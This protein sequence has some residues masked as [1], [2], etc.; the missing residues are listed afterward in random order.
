MERATEADGMLLNEG[1]VS[2]GFL[3]RGRLRGMQELFEGPG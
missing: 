3:L 2:F 1:K